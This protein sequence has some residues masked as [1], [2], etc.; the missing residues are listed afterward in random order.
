MIDDNDNETFA[1]PEPK[2]SASV[3]SAIKKAEKE[4]REWQTT[5]DIIDRRYGLEGVVENTD[6]HD[7]KLD[8]FWASF[9]I[10]KPAIYAKPPV[11]AVAP[12][13]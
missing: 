6:W 12:L 11:P 1:G 4:F 2:S 5:C 9:E 13:F 10:L 8:L 3:L 7:T